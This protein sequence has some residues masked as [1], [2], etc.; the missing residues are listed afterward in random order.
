LNSETEGKLQTL[1]HGPARV[2]SRDELRENFFRLF[3]RSFLLARRQGGGLDVYRSCAETV[4]R[5]CGEPWAQRTIFPSE[6]ALVRRFLSETGLSVANPGIIVQ[7]SLMANP[8]V[9]TWFSPLQTLERSE[10]LRVCRVTGVEHLHSARRSGRGIVFAHSHTLFV[11]LFWV[12]LKH[13]RIR[14]GV[15]IWQWAWGR[16]PEE[17]RDPRIRVVES[18]RELH[19]ATTALRKGEFVHVLADGDKGGR[20]IMLHFCGRQRGFRTTFADLAVAENAQILSTHVTLSADGQIRIDIKAPFSDVPSSIETGEKIRLLVSQYASHLHAL[21]RA[22]PGDISWF[23]MKQH[24]DL[25]VPGDEKQ[26]SGGD[27]GG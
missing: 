11:Q 1:P 8:W 17:I 24:L 3:Q 26:P 20:Q 2:R 15:T 10:F 23:Q 27:R 19:A 14:P 4:H 25:P 18:A 21:W 9:P 13:E 5:L 12:W 16:K 22:N 6:T 7:H